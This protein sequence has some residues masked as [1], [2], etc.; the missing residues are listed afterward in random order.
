M[1]HFLYTGGAFSYTG[2]AILGQ[3]RTREGRFR[4]RDGVQFVHG[5]M[6]M[7]IARFIHGHI[8]KIQ[9]VHGTMG[10][11]IARF[12]HGHIMKIQFVHGTMGMGIGNESRTDRMCADTAAGSVNQTRTYSKYRARQSC[13]N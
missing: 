13:N 3:F 1:V 9:F 7:G 2:G 10:M 12:I 11:G 8:M 6:G 5:T 4:T